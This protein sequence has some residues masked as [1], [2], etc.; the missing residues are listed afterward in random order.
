M[1][2]AGDGAKLPAA[3]CRSPGEG[4]RYVSQAARCARH[5]QRLVGENLPEGLLAVEYGHYSVKGSI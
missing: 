1:V 4:I 3:A 2:H 5:P